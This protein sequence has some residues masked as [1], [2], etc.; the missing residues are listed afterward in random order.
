MIQIKCM[1]RSMQR[2]INNQ[3]SGRF[4]VFL[5][6]QLVSPYN[7]QIMY[8]FLRLQTKH[9]GKITP[10]KKKKKHTYICQFL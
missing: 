9:F 6:L 4:I 8:G 2:I 10:C 1:C 3:H 5:S 7:D